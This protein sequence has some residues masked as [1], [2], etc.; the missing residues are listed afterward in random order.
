MAAMV[1]KGELGIPI[2]ITASLSRIASETPDLPAVL[3]AEASI[4]YGELDQAVSWAAHFFEN[5]G[6]TRQDIVAL[7]LADQHQH[8]ISSIALA[9]LGVAQ[10]AFSATDPPRLKQQFVRRLGITATICDTG[11]R[12]DAFTPV[13]EPPLRDVC[14]VK[15]VKPFCFDGANDANL[16]LLILRTSGTSTGIPKLA[17]LTHGCAR[18]RIDAKG[19]LLPEGPTS[20]YLSLGDLSFNSVKIRAWHCVLTGGCQIGRAHV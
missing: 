18:P 17:L 2:N 12:A 8:L 19:F 6:L 20:R 10:I 11:G 1:G 7:D 14:D 5:E 9:R 3:D 16:P 4:S 13:I 15:A